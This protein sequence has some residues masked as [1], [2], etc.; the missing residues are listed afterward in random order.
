MHKHLTAMLAAGVLI[1]GSGGLVFT[2]DSFASQYDISKPAILEGIVTTIDWA[3]PNSWLTIEGAG[4]NGLQAEF[5]IDLG[6]A[7]ALEHKGWTRDTVKEG[8]PV[9]V[10]GWYARDDRCR[11]RARTLKLHGRELNAASTAVEASA[12]R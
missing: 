9:T 2:H 5:R 12:S 10:I 3:T 11:I 8:D 7:R 1:A 4:T 6:N